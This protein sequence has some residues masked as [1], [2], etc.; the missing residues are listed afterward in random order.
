MN[1]A[2]GFVRGCLELRK[3]ADPSHAEERLS[4]RS[5]HARLGYESGAVVGQDIDRHKASAWLS[6][7]LVST[8]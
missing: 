6:A 3:T 8:E 4:Y 1:G 2:T 5:P 7:V